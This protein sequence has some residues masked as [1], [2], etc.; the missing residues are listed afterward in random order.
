MP[1]YRRRGYLVPKAARLR[2][3]AASAVAMRTP[4]R[5]STKFGEATRPAPDGSLIDMQIIRAGWGSSG[6]YAESV[7]ARDGPALFVK[8]THCYIDHPSVTE[9]SDRPERS[10]RDLA[11][12]LDEDAYSTD[13]GKTL[14][15][16]V[17]VFAP[18][19]EFIREAWQHIGV[20]IRA[21]GTAEPGEAEGR[22]GM[23]IRSLTA[24]E[25]VDFVTRAGAGGK[26]VSLLESARNLRE[27][28]TDHTRQA[29]ADALEDAYG[30]E[31]TYTWVRDFDPDRGLVWFDISAGGNT[32]TWQRP[33]EITDAAAPVATLTGAAAQVVAQT[34]YTP[35]A[36]DASVAEAN[37]GH[38]AEPTPQMSDGDPPAAPENTTTQEEPSMSG[39]QTAG[40]APGAQAGTTAAPGAADVPRDLVV[41]EAQ[42]QV[43]EMRLDEAKTLTESLRTQLTE[44]QKATA[45]AEA[46][47][48]KAE[49]ELRQVRA[50]ETART[51]ATT[52]LASSDLPTAAHAKVVESVSRAVA[53][54]DKGE[55]DQPALTSAVATAIEA[56]R[57]YI[58]S[59]S[60]QAGAGTPTGLGT[61]APTS[62]N[63]SGGTFDA[64]T[65][66][67]G[68][69]ERFQRLGMDSDS[70]ALAARIG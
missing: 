56:E 26:V 63:E 47:A 18:Y 34:V 58:A 22:P 15:A 35:Y 65:F 42:R 44:A 48:D 29:L 30:G 38:T 14:R 49:S 4:I 12:V 24:A 39:S 70:A 69:A 32:D 59:V 62:F 54:T 50:T 13:G 36:S 66:E 11:A 31:N 2:E 1:K 17:R 37:S 51:A 19:R 21:L 20:S 28:A 64:G 10:V 6:H 7:I 61:T 3:S 43:A 23:L 9:E 41:A 67:K 40:A 46:R 68:L 53:L 8:G 5:E 60:Q 33:Y 52:A 27:A 57:T 55:V 45:L 25:S 16:K